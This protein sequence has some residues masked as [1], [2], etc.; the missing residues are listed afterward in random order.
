MRLILSIF[1]LLISLQTKAQQVI[2]L[3][4]QVNTDL[5]ILSDVT[6]DADSIPNGRYLVVYKNKTRVKGQ[7]KFGKMSGIWTTYY[8][9]G[10]Q[11]IKGR[12][13]EGKPHGEWIL[14][15]IQGD[16]QAKFLGRVQL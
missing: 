1:I 8:A 3:K 14:W 4:I 13:I 11:K 7:T 16:V 5:K 10:Q 2:Q 6:A 15:G 9:N 12:Y